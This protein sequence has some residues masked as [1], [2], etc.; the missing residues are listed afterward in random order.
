MVNMGVTA[1]RLNKSLKF[2]S[3]TMQFDDPAANAL[4]NQP[5][6]EPWKIEI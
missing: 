2:D 4:I 1:H 3:K 6:R 5:M